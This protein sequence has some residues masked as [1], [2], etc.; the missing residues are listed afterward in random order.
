MKIDFAN[1]PKAYQE[2]KENF[3]KAISSVIETSSFIMGKPVY[4][5][6]E[7]L[8]TYTGAKYAISCSNGTDA[9]L[10]A[11]MALGIKPGDEIITTPFTFI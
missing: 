11:I 7:R 5:L 3:D 8:S 1:L 9:L 2:H 6:E 10:L 4:E